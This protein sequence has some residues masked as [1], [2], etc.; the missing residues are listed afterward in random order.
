MELPQGGQSGNLPEAAFAQLGLHGHTSP[1]RQ[2]AYPDN[3]GSQA[4]ENDRMRRQE[5]TMER[6]PRMMSDLR[7]S[8]NRMDGDMAEVRRMIRSA[9]KRHRK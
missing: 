8:P 5:R 6:L 4:G 1:T 2:P 3:S 9:R 7:R